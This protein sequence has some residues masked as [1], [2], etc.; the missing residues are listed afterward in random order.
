MSVLKINK[1]GALVHLPVRTLPSEPARGQTV[2]LSDAAGSFR[3]GIL[4]D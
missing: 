4:I 3:N 2:V 1:D